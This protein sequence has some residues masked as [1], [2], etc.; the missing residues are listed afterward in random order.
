MEPIIGLKTL[1]VHP[2]TELYEACQKKNLKLKFVD[3]WKEKATFHVFV[4]DQPVGIGTYKS[5][6]E[7]AHN[8]AAKDALNYVRSLPDL[9]EIEEDNNDCIE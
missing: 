7:I 6:K 2:V 1:E 4:N 8:R 5:K 3:M 9:S